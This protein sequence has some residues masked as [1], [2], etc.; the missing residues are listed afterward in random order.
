MRHESYFGV[1]L[2]EVLIDDRGFVNDRLVIH[3]HGNFAVRIEFEKLPGLVF[4]IALDEFIRNFL[5]G[6]DKP[7]P[8]RVRSRA[9]RKEL[10]TRHLR[11]LLCAFNDFSYRDY[12]RQ[13]SQDI[14]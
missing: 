5:F 3:Q 2:F 9:V 4:E 1:F 13:G 12:R 8:V 10:H 6:Q 7:C 11:F 14:G